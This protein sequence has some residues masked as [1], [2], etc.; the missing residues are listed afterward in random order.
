[1]LT[2]T[3]C[4]NVLERSACQRTAQRCVLLSTRYKLTMNERMQE[5]KN[6]QHATH[7][8]SVLLIGAGI[9]YR[10]EYSSEMWRPLVM[11]RN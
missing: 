8:D 9:F 5:W 2:I 1:M 3:A 6:T 4:V 11:V 7:L 10:L